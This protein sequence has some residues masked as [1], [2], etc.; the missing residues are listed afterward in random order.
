MVVLGA[1]YITMAELPA[2]EDIY[3]RRCLRKGR[4]IVKDCYACYRL[5]SGKT[6]EQLFNG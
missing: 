6:A 2:I 3:T 1:Q 4:R 5:A